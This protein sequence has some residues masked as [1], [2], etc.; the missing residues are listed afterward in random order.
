VRLRVR[1]LSALRPQASA[2]DKPN[3]QNWQAHFDS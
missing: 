3:D 2:K 1:I